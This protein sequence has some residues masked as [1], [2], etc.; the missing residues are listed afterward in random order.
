MQRPRRTAPIFAIISIFLASPAINAQFKVVGP[1][2]FSPTEAREKIQTTLEH[3]DPG[4]REQTIQTLSGWLAWYRDIIDEELVA[5]WKKDTRASLTGLIEPLADSQV[6]SQVIEFSWREQRASAF[7]IAYAPMFG[8]LMVRFPESAQPFLDDLL[9]PRP[10]ELTEPEAEAVARVLL[11]MPDVGAWKKNALQILPH[12]RQAVQTLLKQDLRD[13]DRE[14]SFQAQVWMN[15]LHLDAPSA[16]PDQLRQRRRAVSP[17]LPV[18]NHPASTATPPPAPTVNP[19]TGRP[20]LARAPAPLS[21]APT[22]GTLECTGA[23]IAQNAEYVFRNLP[24]GKL[25]LDYDTK[26]WDARLLPGEG[27]T[28]RLILKNKS[29]GPQKRCVVHWNII[30]NE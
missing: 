15:D 17:D 7:T 29:S 13:S 4:N 1:A 25:Q 20:S 16:A 14:K 3:I 5:G 6:A 21:T 22:S 19:A 8:R 2:P 10:P 18:E 26:N 23:P 30:P 12:Y 28:Q 24:P 11:D 27:Q 9:A